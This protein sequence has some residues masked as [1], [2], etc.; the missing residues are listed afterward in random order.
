MPLFAEREF[1]R[2]LA[3]R[4]KQH[5]LSLPDRTLSASGLVFRSQLS[6]FH[7]LAEMPS[8]HLFAIKE[9]RVAVVGGDPM[10]GV[11]WD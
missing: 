7:C 9:N 1:Y 3:H 2:R 10:V 4:R 8:I 5:I 6:V 11:I